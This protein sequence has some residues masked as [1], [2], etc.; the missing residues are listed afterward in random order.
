MCT[1]ITLYESDPTYVSAKLQNSR[2]T[3]EFMPVTDNG[4]LSAAAPAYEV[5]VQSWNLVTDGMT[6]DDI[7][8]I[9]DFSMGGP[10]SELRLIM[11]PSTEWCP[12]LCGQDFLAHTSFYYRP[13]YE[14]ENVYYVQVWTDGEGENS[15]VCGIRFEG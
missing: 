11:V 13:S 8:I 7:P 1:N 5:E 10:I 15:K 3:F 14:N 9:G 12:L 2:C 6:I 4:S